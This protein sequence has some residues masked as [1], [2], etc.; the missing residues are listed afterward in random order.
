VKRIFTRDVDT[1]DDFLRF[2]GILFQLY[3][4]VSVF[5]ILGTSRNLAGF[6]EECDDYWSN[7][8]LRLLIPKVLTFIKHK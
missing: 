5:E 3:T 4:V 8:A 6:R 1:F 2:S 7:K